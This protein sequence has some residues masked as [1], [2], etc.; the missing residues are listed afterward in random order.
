METFSEMN[1]LCN[2]FG[3]TTNCTAREIMENPH[4][5]IR[6]TVQI[7]LKCRGSDKKEPI[8]K[9]FMGTILIAHPTVNLTIGRRNLH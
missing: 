4:F 8:T 3:D 9:S 6:P 2:M 5:V 7:S 1:D